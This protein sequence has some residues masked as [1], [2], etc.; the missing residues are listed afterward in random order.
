M[1]CINCGNKLNGNELFCT[2]CGAKISEQVKTE[3]SQN[4]TSNPTNNQALQGQTTSEMMS[5]KSRAF[6]KDKKQKLKKFIIKY[7]KQC[8]MVSSVVIVLIVGVILFNNFFGFDK[9]S[10]NEEYEAIKLDY[11][12]PG[13]VKLGI[14]YENPEKIK[15]IKYEVTCGQINSN[16]LEIDWDLNDA[17]GKCKITASYN[18]RK[19]SKEFSIINNNVSE[20]ELA[21]DYKINLD[22]DED[23]DFDGLT[24][25]QEKEYQTSPVLSDSDMDG[26]DD[27]YEIS[28][29]KTDPNKID[30]DEDGLT[31]YDEIELGLD[32]LKTDSKNDGIMDN[33]RTM[34]YIHETDNLRLSITGT[35]NI[36]STI[37]EVN[38]ETKISN[39]TGLIDNLYT[40]YTDGT[41]NE[42]IV[43]ISYTDEQLANYG[44][45]EDNLSIYYYN[46]KEAKY[47]KVDTIIDK[48]NNTLT[49]TLKHFSNYVV[50]DSTLVKETS[51][52]QVLFV[53]DNSWSMYTNEQ[54]KEITGEEYYGGLF[55][56]SKLDG[57]DADGIRFTLTSDL[58]TRLSKKNYQIGLSEFRSDYANALAIGSDAGSIKE[59]LNTMNGSFITSNA[60]TNISNALTNAISEFSDDVDNRYI[61]LLT[62]GQDSSLSSKTSKIIETATEKDVKIC[63]IGFG[64][65]SYNVELS[66]ISNGTGCKFYSSGN[67]EGLN[68]LFENIGAELDDDLVDIDGDS[69]VDG[70]LLADSGFLVNRDGFSFSNYVT[71][72]SSGGHCYGMATVAQLYYLKQLPLK[73]DSI[74]AGDSTSYAYDLTNTYFKNYNNLHDYKL[75]T[76]AFKYSF[77]YEM[78]GEITPVD[79][80]TLEGEKLAYSKKYEKEIDDLGIY[81]RKEEKTQ[82][83]KK[84][85]L[86]RW[87]VNYKTADNLYI[88]E[89]KI[90][91]SSVVKRDD[92]QLFNAI[93]TGFIRQNVTTHYSSGTTFLLWLRNAVGTETT[94]YKGADGFINILKSRLNSKDAPV[95]SAN[96][97]GGLHAVN[98]ISLVQ[99]IDNPN[100]YYIGVYDNNYPGEK[101]Y[102][103][104][105]CKKGKCY[106]VAND[107]YT[108]SGEPIRITP[109]LEY[110]L[111]YY[112]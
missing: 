55:D 41:I 33:Q 88:N 13:N 26:L 91:T 28:T 44:L 40:F 58:V 52:T 46:E 95:I 63:S 50:G 10:W 49:A 109:S 12:S 23:L 81:D 57:F 22:S 82:L 6:I 67:A 8:M 92:T 78:F 70:I 89:D 5:Q 97:S 71:N 30:T 84:T 16:G 85:Q 68:E 72:F 31:D 48:E 36:A 66:N 25:K 90:Q 37:A 4:I 61:V 35:G 79:L 103:D 29:S 24:N 21:L 102:V 96:Y 1:F 69:Q 83:D 76:N 65:G 56:S 64:G 54:Y 47:E 9:L 101:R 32:P 34:T 43:T 18:L 77:G 80:M 94:E 59:K 19:I 87:G 2:K 93:W 105:Q 104:I 14:S 39:K 3:V 38:S 107:Y 106:T 17:I 62:D 108:K 20:Q 27:N 45:N 51:S 11:V 42:A 60:G 100:Y 73:V 74:T 75:Q 111:A 15:D 98:A 86:E 99:D 53:L 7:K 112:K 110:D